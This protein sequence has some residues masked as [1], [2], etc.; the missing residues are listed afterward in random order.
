MQRQSQPTRNEARNYS[1]EPS[2]EYAPAPHR[3]YS[4]DYRPQSPVDE[5][6]RQE[7]SPSHQKYVHEPEQDRYSPSP[8]ATQE[9]QYQSPEAAP[10]SDNSKQRA[11]RL[12]TLLIEDIRLKESQL[13]EV[14]VPLSHRSGGQIWADAVDVTDA[15]QSGPSR[16]DGV[17]LSR[18]NKSSLI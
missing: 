17:S 10:G 15:L 7:S 1:R 13:A 12:V 18:M 6:H 5:S 16:I 2:L 9:A 3:S 11:L 14:Y 8:S 4:P